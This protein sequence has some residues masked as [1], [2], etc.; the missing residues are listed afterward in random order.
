[1]IL[2][3]S[4]PVDNSLFQNIICL[5]TYEKLDSM[6]RIKHPIGKTIFKNFIRTMNQLIPL[7]FNFH[8][9]H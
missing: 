6:I 5:Q 3:Y 1:M 4:Q 7:L 8:I 2:K 9:I